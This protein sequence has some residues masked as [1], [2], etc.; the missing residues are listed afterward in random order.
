MF[1]KISRYKKLDN[2]V[3]SGIRGLSIES[4]SLRPT[5]E[6]G[7]DF[8]HTLLETDRLDHLARKYYKQPRK[9]WR[10][11]DADPEFMSPL[12]LVGDDPVSTACLTVSFPGGPEN[13]PLYKLRKKLSETLGVKDVVFEAN[14]D[15][16]TE[17][18]VIY[19]RMNVKMTDLKNGAEAEG[20]T[21]DAA[22]DVGRTGKKIVIPPRAAG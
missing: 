14:P 18:T 5:P 1:S 19:N 11:C 20:F 3:T 21:V 2:I 17:V 13:P 10:I 7:G 12:A 6:T 9:W 22:A 15:N 8:E 4:K 16:S